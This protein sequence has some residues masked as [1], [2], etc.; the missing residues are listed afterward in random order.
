MVDGETRTGHT[1]YC[2]EATG[3]VLGATDTALEPTDTGGRLNTTLEPL[4][5]DE[6]LHSIP[7]TDRG[8]VNKTW[9]KVPKVLPNTDGGLQTVLNDN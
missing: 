9:K 2:T 3:V 1:I 6:A 8:A 5:T 4:D 7:D